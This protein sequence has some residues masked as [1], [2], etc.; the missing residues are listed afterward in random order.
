MKC[1][2]CQKEVQRLY[3]VV[4]DKDYNA[5]TK[6]ALWNCLVCYKKKNKE[7]NDLMN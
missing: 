3:R 5:L 6:R 7:R 4:I 2:T 1:D